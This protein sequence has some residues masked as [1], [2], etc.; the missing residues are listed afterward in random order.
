MFTTARTAAGRWCIVLAAIIGLGCSGCVCGTCKS[1]PVC[2]LPPHLLAPTRSEMI[3]IDYTLLR[4][5]PPPA[6]VIGPEDIL[7]IHI[8]DVLGEGEEPTPVY[9]DAFQG[10]VVSP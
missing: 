2:R 1:V 9:F 10:E 8:E 3:P 4:Q 5:T 7:G 6:H